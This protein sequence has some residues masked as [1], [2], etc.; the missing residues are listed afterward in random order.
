MLGGVEKAAEEDA[1]KRSSEIDGRILGWT[2]RALGDDESLEKFF[3]AIPGFFNSKL[4][5]DL[6]RYFPETH[7]N[8]FWLVLDGFMGRTSS[9]NSV[10]ESVKSH[11]VLICRDIITMIPC[12]FFLY[13]PNLTSHFDQ[14]PVSIERL[15]AIA[16][17]FTH[18]S[19]NVSGA[20]RSRVG[21]N[22]P[23]I[24]EHDNRWIALARDAYGIAAHDIEHIVAL[25]GDN[26]LLA[27]L[28]HVSRQ[29]IHSY[30]EGMF[31][32]VRALTQFDIRYTLPGP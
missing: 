8:T 26:V 27:I 10:T 17:W 32:F 18:L 16:R 25:G 9:S 19:D 5:K 13:T 31:G 7:L 4:V 24:Q 21:V 12:P 2:I 1:S 29:A 15:Q 14:A 30:K 6:E 11:R 28:I 20:A 22:L 3:E 23:K